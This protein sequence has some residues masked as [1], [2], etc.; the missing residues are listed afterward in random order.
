MTVPKNILKL[1]RIDIQTRITDQSALFARPEDDFRID[2]LVA[3]GDRVAQGAPVL[4]SRRAPE[5]TL[6]APVAG[7]IAS[8][9]LGRG[10]E[11][12]VAET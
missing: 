8:I 4:R 6:V 3:E 2:L 9:E 11:L 1:A 7:E 5:L 12:G 10:V